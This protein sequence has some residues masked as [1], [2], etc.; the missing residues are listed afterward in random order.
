MIVVYSDF[1]PYAAERLLNDWC[2]NLAGEVH[3]TVDP[4]L[5]VDGH[6]ISIC[7]DEVH[8]SLR[9][10]D[11]IVLAH[12][13]VHAKQYLKGELRGHTWKGKQYE[14]DFFHCPWEQQAYALENTFKNH[15]QLL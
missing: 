12:E 2:P 10:K 8:I 3:I 7:D 15:L 13:L 4:E 11:L 1:L 5:N 6:C 14:P 9:S